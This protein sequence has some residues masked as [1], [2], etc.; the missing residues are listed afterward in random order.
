MHYKTMVLELFKQ[1]PQLHDQLRKDRM[2]RPAMA[3]YAMELKIRH[4]AW[5]ERLSR[6]R[7]GSDPS[8]I[9]SEALEI[10]LRDLQNFLPSAS[11]ADE[12]DQ[13]SLDEAMAFLRRH[14]PPE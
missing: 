1:R 8:Q 11:P 13:L 6:A 9:A 10:A 14:T 5:K 4:E 7:P 12:G 3:T 2:L